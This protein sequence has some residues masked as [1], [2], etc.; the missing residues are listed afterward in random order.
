MT[1]HG[2]E[3]FR[4]FRRRF[5]SSWGSFLCRM[6]C[7]RV[8][9]PALFRSRSI[10]CHRKRP[11][12]SW[13][14]RRAA[15]RGRFPPLLHRSHLSP[16]HACVATTVLRGCGWHSGIDGAARGGNTLPPTAPAR[17]APHLQAA[18]H[19]R[20]SN[21]ATTREEEGDCV[22]ECLQGACGSAATGCGAGPP[23]APTVAGGT[24]TDTRGSLGGG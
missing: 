17:I 8:R 20:P 7:L 5:Q 9:C 15:V 16:P 23:S 10:V 13:S 3:A 4:P 18:A 19:S 24:P 12:D 22:G 1:C 11:A 2:L 14:P 6:S 21:L